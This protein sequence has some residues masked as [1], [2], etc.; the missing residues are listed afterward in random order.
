MT[1]RAGQHTLLI[2]L[3]ATYPQI[4]VDHMTSFNSGQRKSG[5][6]I[7]ALISN[8]VRFKPTAALLPALHQ[9]PPFVRVPF[10]DT[11]QFLD[12]ILW[13]RGFIS[14]SRPPDL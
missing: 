5:T 8:M 1:W 10:R 11:L 7:S 6:F 13:G 3:A 12:E 9:N 2:T 14:C 4:G